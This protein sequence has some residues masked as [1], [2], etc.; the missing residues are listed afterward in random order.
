MRDLVGL[1]G[2]EHKGVL[3]GVFNTGCLSELSLKLLF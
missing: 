3:F 2:G 1:G